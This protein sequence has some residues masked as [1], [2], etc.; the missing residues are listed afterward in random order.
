MINDIIVVDDCVSKAYQDALEQSFVKNLDLPIYLCPSVTEDVSVMVHDDSYGFSHGLYN[1]MKGGKTSDYSD[2]VVPLIYEAAD[3]INYVVK[4]LLV[5]RYF[6]L[7][8]NAQGTK[9]NKMH[10][11]MRDNH[12]V[13]IYY[14]NDSTGP[15]YI[16]KFNYYDYNETDINQIA[17]MSYQKIV[18]P[19]KGRMVFFNGQFYHA[20]SNPTAGVRGILNF[21]VR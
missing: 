20:S 16:S 2:F 14:L 9:H 18:E 5:S 13:G 17:N 11:D 21:N 7:T 15:T 10:V 6:L 4:E 1:F 12:L 8:A 19:K 3:K